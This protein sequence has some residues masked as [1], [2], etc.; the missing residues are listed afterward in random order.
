MQRS[1]VKWT[2]VDDALPEIPKGK[3]GIQVLAVFYDPIYDEEN[4][5]RCWYVSDCSYFRVVNNRYY[6]NS[7]LEYD[8][9]DLYI[10]G[11]DGDEWGPTGDKVVYWAYLPELPKILIKPK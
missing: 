3:Y 7:K 5:S 11:N 8:F 10:G 9:V 4:E 1:E 6:E 2:H